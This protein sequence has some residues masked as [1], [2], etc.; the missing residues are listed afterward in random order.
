MPTLLFTLSG[1]LQSWGAGRRFNTVDTE[2]APTKSGVIGLLAAALG[3]LRE[4]PVADLA[5][6]TFGVRTEQQGT[7]SPDFHTAFSRTAGKQRISTRWY[8]ADAVFLVGVEGDRKFLEELDTAL[9]RPTFPL[10]LGRRSC[11]AG[12]IDPTLVDQPL[13]EALTQAPWAAARWY[14]DKYPATTSLVITR[15]VVA[16]EMPHRQV[17]D[18]PLSFAT[19]HQ[20][21]APRGV[22]DDVVRLAGASDPS[23][24]PDLDTPRDPLDFIENL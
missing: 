19:G 9:R 21:H 22:V 12:R 16:G 13:T 14:Q 23:D 18:L 4:E 15:D 6:L 8:L 2:A 20:Q 7:R 5:A 11:P 17:R 3:R 24:M 1:P 10:F